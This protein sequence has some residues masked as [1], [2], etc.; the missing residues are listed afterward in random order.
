MSEPQA[1]VKPFVQKS[2]ISPP[3]GF[4]PAAPSCAPSSA[5]WPP[6]LGQRQGRGAPVENLRWLLLC[7]EIKWLSASCDTYSCSAAG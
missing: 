1:L 2:W 5:W 3:V 7:A 6:R 4:A